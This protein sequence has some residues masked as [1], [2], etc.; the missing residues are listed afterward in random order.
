MAAWQHV[1]TISLS[2]MTDDGRYSAQLASFSL[3]C[4]MLPPL[5]QIGRLDVRA[6]GS[7]LSLWTRHKDREMMMGRGCARGRGVAKYE[8][9]S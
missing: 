5:A 6:P 3:L 8:S 1:V 4:Y 2:D 9:L 7:T